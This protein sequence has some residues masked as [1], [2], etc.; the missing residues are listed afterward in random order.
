MF[1]DV[2]FGEFICPPSDGAVNMGSEGPSS[3]TVFTASGPTGHATSRGKKQKK[4]LSKY[5]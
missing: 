3:S 4:R 2:P 1:A 5:A